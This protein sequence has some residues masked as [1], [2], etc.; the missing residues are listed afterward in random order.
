[1]TGTIKSIATDGATG[2]RRGFG[3]ITC[4]DGIDV[5]MHASQVATAFA[6]FEVG[7]RVRFDVIDSPRGLRAVS[8]TWADR[9]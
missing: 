9:T 7:D 6:D 3:F 2:E 1:V 8:V 5:F 4:D